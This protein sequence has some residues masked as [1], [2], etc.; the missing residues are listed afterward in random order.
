MS[1][2]PKKASAKGK[3]GSSA[4]LGAVILAVVLLVVV[5]NVWQRAR[6]VFALLAA[7]VVALAFFSEILP[8]IKAKRARAAEDARKQAAAPAKPMSQEEIRQLMANFVPKSPEEKT[9]EYDF[10][11][12][13]VGVFRPTDVTGPMPE[14]GDFLEPAEEPEN[15]Y[16]AEAILLRDLGGEPVGYLNR[17]KIRETVRRGLREA[18]PMTVQ[19]SRADDKLEVYIGVDKTEY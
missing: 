6:W 12:T 7:A 3:G 15:P 9:G 19:V 18:A 10:E 5:V 8:R 11:Y 2:K 17:G 14:V 13:C 4:T 1:K 16:D